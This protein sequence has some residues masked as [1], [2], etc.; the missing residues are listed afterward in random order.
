M[1]YLE[2]KGCGDDDDDDDV[3]VEEPW[4]LEQG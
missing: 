3:P 4:A 1:G 2:E